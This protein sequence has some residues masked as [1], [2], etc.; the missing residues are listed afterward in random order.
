MESNS[1]LVSQHSRVYSRRSAERSA[2]LALV[3]K[4]LID[5]APTPIILLLVQSISLANRYLQHQL[6]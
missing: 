2:I 6:R 4:V 1:L 3:F 5:L